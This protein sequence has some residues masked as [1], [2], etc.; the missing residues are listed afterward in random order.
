VKSLNMPK[1][2]YVP[3]LLVSHAVLS[4]S[5]LNSTFQVDDCNWNWK[6][7]FL[8][9]TMEAISEEGLVELSGY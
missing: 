2:S 9:P 8:C 4:I 7:K 6:K 5:M 3:L 1:F